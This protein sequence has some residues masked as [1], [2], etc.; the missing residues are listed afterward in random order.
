MRFERLII[1][2]SATRPDQRVTVADI[3][4]WHVDDRGWS[5]IGYHGIVQRDGTLEYGRSVRRMG[6]HV[7]GHNRDS[8]GLCLI[9]GHGSAE[10]D[11]FSDHFTDLQRATLTALILA[12]QGFGLTIHGHNEYASK[13]C[14]GFNVQD[15]IKGET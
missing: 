6:A 12:A 5:D 14:P 8:L 2:C 3:R 1:H 11:R 4:R 13:A 7:R 10:T 9:G 15:F